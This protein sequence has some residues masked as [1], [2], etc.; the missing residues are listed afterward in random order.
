MFIGQN[1]FAERLT[2]I[3][4]DL[5]ATTIAERK[6]QNLVQRTLAIKYTTQ[7]QTL[8]IQVK[9][10]NRALIAQ[11]KQGLKAKVQDAIIL[12]EDAETL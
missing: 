3:F 12:I 5:E 11:Y 7:F 9:W 10:N 6:L 1:R 8:I 4:R 2:Q